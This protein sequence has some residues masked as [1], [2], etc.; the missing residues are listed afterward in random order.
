MIV[1]LLA[2]LLIVV[3][4]YGAPSKGNKAKK[5]LSPAGSLWEDVKLRTVPHSSMNTLSYLLDSSSSDIYTNVVR[6]ILYVIHKK[7]QLSRADCRTRRLMVVQMS[8]TSFEG[9][10]SLLKQIQFSVAVA[11]HSNRSMIWGIGFPFMFEHSKDV[12][13]G[14]GNSAVQ[15][16]GQTLNCS[17][18][19]PLAGPIG[20]FFEPLTSCSLADVAPAE[21]LEF[22]NNAWNDSARLMLVEVRKGVSLYY[23]PLG[24]MEYISQQRGYSAQQREGIQQ[25]EAFLWA[26]AVSAYVFR[27]K[28]D[29]LHSFKNKF[30]TLRQG[31]GSLWGLHVRHGDLKALSNVYGYKEVFDFEDYFSAAISLSHTL[32]AV[33]DKL[34]VSTDSMQADRLSTIFSRFLNERRTQIARSQNPKSP[35]AQKAKSLGL[36]KSR[37]VTVDRQGDYEDDDEDY[38]EEDDDEEEDEEDEEDEYYDD[39]GPG[40]PPATKRYWYNDQVPGIFTIHNNDRY[41][42]EHGSH[43]VAANGGCQRDEKYTEKG[44]R[45][46]LNYQAIVHYQTME[47]HRSVPR[48]M[49]LVRVMLEAIEDLYFLSQCDGLIAQGSSHFSTLASLLIWAR[50]GALHAGPKG[51]VVF[52]DEDKIAKG[53]VPTAF[54]HGMNLLNG[55]HSLDESSSAQGVQRWV[56]HTNY[57]LSGVHSHQSNNVKLTY[58]PWAADNRM[59][60]MPGGMPQL[61][62]KIF[63]NEAKT[64]LGNAG[65]KYKPVWPGM[66]PG[67]FGNLHTAG[68]SALDYLTT[69]INLGVEHLS[70]SHEGQALQCWADALVVLDEHP[71]VDIPQRVQ[72]YRSVATE[73]AGTLKKLKYAEMIINE[74]H[75]TRDFLD[76]QDR[77]MRKPATDDSKAGMKSLEDVNEEIAG[78]EQQLIKLKELRDKLISA[79]YMMLSGGIGSQNK[80]KDSVRLPAY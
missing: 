29:L 15:V 14:P 51:S 69:V 32:Q 3:L 79:N 8:S 11:M 52:L 80:D 49:R 38:E 46:A 61:P 17:Q 27:I 78:I 25:R 75:S 18:A 37:T 21:M 1:K 40:A 73:N 13:D 19:D 66:C 68:W 65:K 72:E 7:Q 50:T 76:Y 36:G 45:C 55:T 53:F 43:T 22:S 67:A 71:N 10:G 77:Y 12:W 64:W 35:D 28:P 30:S 39:E 5:A 48:S 23:P 74:N 47:E 6:D 42:T 33:P 20:C 26:A 4:A 70:H 41:R 9:I 16:N 57:F 58:N 62:S 34:F 31:A 63:Y 2:F 59:A 54:L 56:V 44:M 60:L 24:L